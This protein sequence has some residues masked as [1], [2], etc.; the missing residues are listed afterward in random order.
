[1]K[2]VNPLGAFEKLIHKTI[3]SQTSSVRVIIETLVEQRK[4]ILVILNQYKHQ[5]KT[6][7]KLF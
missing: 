5:V 6:R 7:F 1:M 4:S 2:I 3:Q